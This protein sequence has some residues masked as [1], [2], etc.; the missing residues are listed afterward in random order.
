MVRLRLLV[1]T[2]RPIVLP[3]PKALACWI[4]PVSVSFSLLEKPAP[5]AIAPV[6]F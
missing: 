5:S 6:G 2:S 3:L 4:E 1:L